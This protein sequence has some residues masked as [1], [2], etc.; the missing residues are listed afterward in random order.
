MAVASSYMFGPL[1]WPSLGCTSKRKS[2]WVPC[3]K[4]L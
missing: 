4:T 2:K 1:W 3:A